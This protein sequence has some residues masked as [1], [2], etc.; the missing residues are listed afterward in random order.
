MSSDDRR[1]EESAFSYQVSGDESLSEGVIQAVSAVSN[2][3]P[4]ANTR[5]ESEAGRALEPLYSI[6]DPEALD[7]VFRST[8]SGE[9][10]SCGR[11]TFSYHGCDVTVREG[12]GISVKPLAPGQER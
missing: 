10:R 12:G 4:V 11:V 8:D 2:A 7:S 6:L 5:S 9:S 3:D 1:I